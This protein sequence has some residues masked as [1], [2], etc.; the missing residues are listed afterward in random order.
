MIVH[1]QSL[2]FAVLL[3][4][5]VYQPMQPLPS[6]THPLLIHTTKTRSY[7]NIII[8]LPPIF[9]DYENLQRYYRGSLADSTDSNAALFP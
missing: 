1:A 2:H 6:A 9:I 4:Y 3:R 8:S 5:R 7:S